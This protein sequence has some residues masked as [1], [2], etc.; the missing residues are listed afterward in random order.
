M[1]VPVTGTWTAVVPAF[2][3][4]TLPSVIQAVT[5]PPAR[6]D[7]HAPCCASV[8]PICVWVSAISGAEARS[9]AVS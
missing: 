8:W 7:A 9:N 2:M 4:W 5:F 3:R 1:V 6:V